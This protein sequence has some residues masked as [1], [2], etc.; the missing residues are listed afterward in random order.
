MKLFLLMIFD[1]SLAFTKKYIIPLIILIVTG[2]IFLTGSL[3]KPF[4]QG[5]TDENTNW[6]NGRFT[7]TNKLLWF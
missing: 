1:L 7:R 4:E 2:I 5:N 6:K 3:F